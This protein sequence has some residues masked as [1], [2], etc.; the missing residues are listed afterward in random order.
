M[1][2]NVYRILIGPLFVVGLTLVSNPTF[3]R[4]GA[5]HGGTFAS[6]QT[7]FHSPAA[8]SFRHHRRNDGAVV[9]PADDGLAYGPTG[10]EPAAGATPPGPGDVNYKFTYDVPWDWAHRYP[11]AVVPSDR[12][13]VSSCPEETVTF[14]GR[15]GKDRSVNVM[16]C[17]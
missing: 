16:R 6:P 17:Y 8:R 9:W 3:A 7:P 12:P 2:R 5:A 11:P 13:Y 14:P 10:T 1:K 15:D 4:P